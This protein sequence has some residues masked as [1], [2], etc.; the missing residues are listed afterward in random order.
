MFLRK[1]VTQ[2]VKPHFWTLTAQ[3]PKDGHHVMKLK[4]KKSSTTDLS[5][6]RMSI[7]CKGKAQPVECFLVVFDAWWN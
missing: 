4:V 6:L 3:Q 1:N 5:L 7:S 2:L